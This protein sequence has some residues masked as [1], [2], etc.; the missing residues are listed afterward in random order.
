MS[1]GVV[2]PKT[3]HFTDIREITELAA[4]QRHMNGNN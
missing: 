4:E 2:S 1:S 3:H